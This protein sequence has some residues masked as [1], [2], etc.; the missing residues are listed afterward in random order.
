MELDL[1]DVL[2]T[3]VVEPEWIVEGIIPAATIVMRAGDPGVGKTKFSLSE[4]MH[5]ALG[6]AFIGHP[7]HQCRVLYFDEENSRPDLTA[8]MQ[9]VWIGM[10][11]PDPALVRQWFRLEHFSLG[12]ADWHERMQR[13]ATQWGPG[14][15]Y[16][17]TATSALAIN[18]EN[19]NSEAHRAAQALRHVI[20]DTA[21]HPAVNILKHAK[22]QQGDHHGSVSRTIR[23]AKAWIGA[24]D[25]TQYYI[26][27]RG[28]PRL[29]GL[30]ESTLVK[31]K[32]RAFGLRGN[33]HIEPIWTDDSPKGLYFEGK[34]DTSGQNAMVIS[35]DG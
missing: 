27:R 12:S 11:M 19:D 24:V 7:T 13:I 31:D 9:Q 6:R 23:G 8:Y 34:Y 4:G 22:F 29:D 15:L 16:V 20:R 35:P 25:Q 33:I 17:D 21:T 18:E 28:R 2:T 30:H 5:I 32:S 10:G 1:T 26:K 3:K 14:M